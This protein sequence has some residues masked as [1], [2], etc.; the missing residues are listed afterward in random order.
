MRGLKITLRREQPDHR[1]KQMIVSE[2]RASLDAFKPEGGVT[3]A[4]P[5]AS[6]DRKMNYIEWVH[7][8]DAPGDAVDP[9]LTCDI[10]TCPFETS[11]A[12]ASET[13]VQG[14]L[15]RLSDFPD[16][17][18]V[19]IVVPLGEHPDWTHRMLDI[20]SVSAGPDG[21]RIVTENWDLAVSQVV[22]LKGDA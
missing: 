1:G 12:H 6:G 15:D 18:H 4:I 8:L 10:E 17:M 9:A 11:H 22:R 21:V 7:H 20:A 3:V 19:R 14:I 2:L 16:G 13:R 5:M